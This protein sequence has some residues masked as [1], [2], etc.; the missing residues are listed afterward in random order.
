MKSFFALTVLVY[1]AAVTPTGGSSV[2]TVAVG[3]PFVAVA[4]NTASTTSS[5]ESV[6]DTA[7]T[8]AASTAS[9][10]APTTTT[11]STTTTTTSTTTTPKPAALL[12]ASEDDCP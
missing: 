8:S 3:A 4:N 6:T 9:T 12:D 7:A 10:I 11:T 5:I 1:A 2:A